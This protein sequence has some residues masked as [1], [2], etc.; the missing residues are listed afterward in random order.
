MKMYLTSTLFNISHTLYRINSVN[1]RKY[2]H[3]PSVYNPLN[4][5]KNKHHKSY[6]QLIRQL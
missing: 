6:G 4:R 1:S 2:H 3:S 5:E